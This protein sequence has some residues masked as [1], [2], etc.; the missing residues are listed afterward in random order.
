MFLDANALSAWAE[1]TPEVK[2]S[3]GNASHIAIL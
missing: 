2:V 1:G 3:L